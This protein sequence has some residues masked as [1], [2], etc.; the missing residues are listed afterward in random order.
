MATS[1]K[2]ATLGNPAQRDFAKKINSMIDERKEKMS[3][4]KQKQADKAFEKIMAKVR[5]SRHGVSGT[6]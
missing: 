5:A 6:R 1:P 3:A 2:P 4:S